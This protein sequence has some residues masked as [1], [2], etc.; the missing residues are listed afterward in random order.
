LSRLRETLQTDD[1]EKSMELIQIHA[2]VKSSFA[3]R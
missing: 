2:L 1:L 3:V